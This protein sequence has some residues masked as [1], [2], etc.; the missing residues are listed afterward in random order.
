[1]PEPIDLH[2]TM[3]QQRLADRGWRC[4]RRHFL[5]GGIASLAVALFPASALA[6]LRTPTTRERSL[7]LYNIHTGESLTAAYWRDGDYLPD[8]RQ[9]I[10]HLLRDYRTGDVEAIHPAL[11]DL[12]FAIHRRL[13]SGAPIHVISGYRSP[14]TNEA[15][16]RDG[17]GV[18]RHSLHMEGLAVDFALPD[19]DLKAM[20]RTAVDLRGGG[21]GYYPASGFLHVDVGRVR[22]W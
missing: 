12:L 20:R 2:D 6:T 18:A 1:M 11:L 14:A 13:D 21:V 9:A 5:R 8:A 15:L 4:D 16:R 19:R 7:T 10:D 3:A 22:Y 17:H